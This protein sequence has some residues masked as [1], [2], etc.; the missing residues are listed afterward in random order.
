MLTQPVTLT[1]APDAVNVAGD[2][3]GTRECEGA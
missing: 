1:G 2:A 3:F